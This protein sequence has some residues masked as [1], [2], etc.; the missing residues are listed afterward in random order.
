MTPRMHR[1]AVALVGPLGLLSLLLGSG[2]ARAETPAQ[3]AAA[4]GL[5]GTWAVDCRLPPSIANAW[6]TY[7][8]TPG[9]NIAHDRDFGS[10]RNIGEVVRAT[11]TAGG[12]DLVVF[13]PVSAQ[14]RQITITKAGDGRMRTMTDS[15]IN[16]NEYAVRDGVL[17]ATG[18]QM[19]WQMR[20]R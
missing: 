15:F 1:L 17:L 20:C 19:P 18:T 14:S 16:A 11:L 12:I 3:T 2:Q 7:A 6:L 4:F 13:F 8:A 9:G 5:L 10:Q